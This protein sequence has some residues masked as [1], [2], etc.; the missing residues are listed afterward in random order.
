MFLTHPIVKESRRAWLIKVKSAYEP[1]SPSGQ[2]LSRFP[3][4]ETSW[5]ISTTPWMGASN[6]GLEHGPLNPQM[7][8]LTI[9]DAIVPWLLKVVLCHDQTESICTK[10]AY[11]FMVKGRNIT[12]FL[13]AC[14]TTAYYSF[15]WNVTRLTSPFD[16]CKTF[17][18]TSWLQLPDVTPLIRTPIS[19]APCFM[20]P[21]LFKG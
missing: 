6:P 7:S 16:V 19:F 17:E 21:L 8:T 13:L 2:S 4:Y 20:Q 11:M 5:N 12:I 9:Y 10:H 14:M 15:S 1:S 18:V 3:W